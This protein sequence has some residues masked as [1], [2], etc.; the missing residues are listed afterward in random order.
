M[1]KYGHRI[2]ANSKTRP[3]TVIPKKTVKKQP[4]S[5]P[6]TTTICGREV[7]QKSLFMQ[8]VCPKIALHSFHLKRK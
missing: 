6:N 3:Y 5:D 7:W 2:Y 8:K 1:R 4:D